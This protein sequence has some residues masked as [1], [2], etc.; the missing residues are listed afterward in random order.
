MAGGSTPGGGGPG[1]GGN[2]SLGPFFYRF[3]VLF[4][5]PPKSWASSATAPSGGTEGRNDTPLPKALWQIR[6]LLAVKTQGFI[7]PQFRFNPGTE[8]SPPPA[9][10]TGSGVRGN[11]LVIRDPTIDS[12]VRRH[13]EQV[14]A[15]LNSLLAHGYIRQTD[16]DTFEL[17]N[18]TWVEGR[19]PTAFDDEEDNVRVGDLWLNT[20]TGDVYI[21]RSAGVGNAVWVFIG[22]SGPGGSGLTG[23]FP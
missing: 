5:Q 19:A 22:G 2:P 21:N 4:P 23:T 14:S 18:R 13:T 7:P 20:A 15:I 8:T 1:S 6:P 11:P 16:I 3:R 9:P 10:S 12:R 17:S